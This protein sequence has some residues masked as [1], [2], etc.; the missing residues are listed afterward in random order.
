[1][2]KTRTIVLLLLAG[3]MVVTCA[4]CSRKKPTGT[5]AQTQSVAPAADVVT[6]VAGCPVPE[7]NASK[8][9]VVRL[10]KLGIAAQYPDGGF[11]VF[12]ARRASMVIE[13]SQGLKY[14]ALEVRKYDKNQKL[15]WTKTFPELTDIC[16]AVAVTPDGGA[17][18][19]TDADYRVRNELDMTSTGYLTKISAQG[20]VA[21]SD[22][23]TKNYQYIDSIQV[24][25]NGDL[26]TSGN[27]IKN[28][29]QT[30]MTDA[31]GTWQH[32]ATDA[33]TAVAL[34]RYDSGGKMLAHQIVASANFSYG[35]G[36]GS[37]CTTAWREG[38]GL[39]AGYGSCCVCYDANLQK[40]WVY[41]YP[42]VPVDQ[43]EGRNSDYLAASTM[44]LTNKNILI[45]ATNFA[46]T[47][48]RVLSLTFEG[49]LASSREIALPADTISPY[50]GS[51]LTPVPDGR[52]VLGQSPSS[53]ASR[54]QMSLLSKDTTNTFARFEAPLRIDGLLP[55]TDGGF[56]INYATFDDQ[57][58]AA[59]YVLAKY[60]R[61]GK[62]RY[63]RVLKAPSLE[64][65][66]ANLYPPLP[67]TYQVL[68][69]GLILTFGS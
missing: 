60:T 69:S 5:S 41:D 62:T 55:G 30:D 32:S 68:P 34:A 42:D 29:G 63:Q 20:S 25:R 7:I 24:A 36:G 31:E 22:K 28:N 57:G 43:S 35:G 37:S 53:G 19:V 3:L 33:F 66:A 64:E 49:K 4:A 44:Q 10:P 40:Q 48:A 46:G 18:V 51:S 65:L 61:A 58:N 1:M 11:I 45:S 17:V 13:N 38:M 27:Y 23:L 67:Y 14:Q 59:W 15:L 56:T 2:R 6:R 9:R 52:V 26:Y 21:W 12:L 54:T 47:K 50:G 16:Y 8:A 39:I